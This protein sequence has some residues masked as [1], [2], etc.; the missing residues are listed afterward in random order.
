M[1][2]TPTVLTIGHSTHPIGAFLDL[3][4]R[5][6]VTAVADVRSSPFSRFNPQYNRDALT[7]SL[8][9]AGIAYV[10]LGDAL[11]ARA[12]DPSCYVNGRVQYDRLARRP[13]F[14]DGIARVKNGAQKR[15]IALMCA[16][17]EPLDCHRTLLVARALAA[18]GVCVAHILGDGALEPHAAAMDR[19]IDVTGLPRNDLFRSRDEIAAEALRIQEQRVAYVDAELAAGREEPAA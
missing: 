7:R 18:E 15:R 13:A 14:L 10:F 5:H 17:R 2:D 4:A 19:L 6:G 1:T 3:L 9:A 16:E 12:D 11:G 8:K